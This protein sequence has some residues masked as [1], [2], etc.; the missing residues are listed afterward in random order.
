M[1]IETCYMDTPVTPL[2]IVT[3]WP[4]IVKRIDFVR[5]EADVSF[6]TAEEAPEPCR[7]TV[8]Q[9]QEYFAG[10]RKVFELELDPEG[11]DFQKRVWEELR[12]IPF[13]E[14]INYGEQA[15]RM[16]RLTAS[17]AVGHANGSNPISIIVPCHRVIGA[18]GHLTGY[19][20][21]LHVKQALLRL[22]GHQVIGE[23]LLNPSWESQ[24][25]L[26]L[27]PPK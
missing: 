6:V 15:R 17:R 16:G 22:E 14:V 25:S 18:N 13:G 2:R 4:G 26:D 9:L 10:T 12:N 27:L 1:N 7:D 19:A 11:T 3:E 5:K 24:A 8:R 23:R 21:G 20:G